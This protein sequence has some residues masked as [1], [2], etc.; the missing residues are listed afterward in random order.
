[1]VDRK[2]VLWITGFG[3]LLLLGGETLSTFRPPRTAVIDISEVFEGYEKKKELQTQFEADIQVVRDKIT[4]LEKKHKE[5]LEELP[6][7][8]PGDRKAKLQ[9]EEFKLKQ[10]A[11]DLQKTETGRLRETQYKYLKEIRDEITREI[12]AYAEAEDLDLV[13]EATVV[14][15]M[16]PEIGQFRW[17]LAHYV[18]PELEITNE[19]LRRLNDRYRP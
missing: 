8:G 17:P 19:I 16:G 4:E 10:Q 14:G 18:K 12:R 1:M 7:L 6:N 15:D 2:F 11:N 5:L 13:L 9:L 3:V